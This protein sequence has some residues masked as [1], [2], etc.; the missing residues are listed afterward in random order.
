MRRVTALLVAALAVVATE[1]RAQSAQDVAAWAALS[2]TPIGALTPLVVVPSVK[3]AK[4]QSGHVWGVH[5]SEWTPSGGDAV[6]N[7][8]GS[9]MTGY[10]QNAVVG[11][12][13]GFVQPS[14]SGCDGDIM[15]SLDVHSAMWENPMASSSAS[16]SV[17]SVLVHG[18]LGYS[19]NLASGGGNSYSVAATVPVAYRMEQA[20]GSTIAFFL[21][22]GFGFGNISGGGTSEHGTRP[23]F[24]G[25]A[26]YTTASGTGFHLGLQK[27]IINGGST[28]FGFAM[29]FR[30]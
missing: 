10:G 7:F 17:L 21:A 16:K 19:H 20:A 13:G 30:R 6:Y 27:V 8:A 23:L 9:Y 26:S 11:V 1:A 4:A 25:G 2:F 5:A 22:P 15:G 3:N 28:N 18:S 29:T 14:C 12:T 24:G